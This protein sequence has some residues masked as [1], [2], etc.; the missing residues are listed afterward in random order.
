MPPISCADLLNATAPPSPVLATDNVGISSGNISVISLGS[1][2]NPYES[3]A[4]APLQDSQTFFS[5]SDLM[6][7][8]SSLSLTPS[9][10]T[11]SSNTPSSL[12][13][14]TMTPPF[15]SLAQRPVAPP[16]VIP[17]GRKTKKRKANTDLSQVANNAAQH[18]KLGKKARKELTMVA[19]LNFAEQLVW[20]AALS[21]SVHSRLEK[22]VG[23]G[24]SEWRM[25]AE[26]S[27]FIKKE[28]F[29]LLLRPTLARYSDKLDELSKDIPEPGPIEVLW[30]KIKE[31]KNINYQPSMHKAAAKRRVIN[32]FIRKNFNERRHRIKSKIQDSLGAKD[33]DGVDLTPP[34]DI[35][36]LT[37]NIISIL[38][39]SKVKLSF[40]R[41]TR[42]SVLRNAF[43]LAQQN[44]ADY[45]STVDQE[46]HQVRK[47]PSTLRSLYFK[48]ILDSDTRIYGSP[49]GLKD[50]RTDDEN[51]LEDSF[52]EEGDDSGHSDDASDGNDD[53]DDD[54]NEG[55]DDDDD[56]E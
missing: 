6:A 7:G 51:T 35:I 8:H 10:S 26:L 29:I 48:N 43:V 13:P 54:D 20:T 46:L 14:L 17:I 28:S 40:E 49:D 4:R 21:L 19:K 5:S 2:V 50:L 23:M 55:D 25:P 24:G 9:S 47:S 42:V 3:D 53:D 38:K 32:L 37:C 16:H 41:V 18:H 15:F 22:G 27:K 52:C 44:K 33:K 34:T 45:W 36:K 11:P 30:A 31:T 1:S 12:T 39:S 56:D